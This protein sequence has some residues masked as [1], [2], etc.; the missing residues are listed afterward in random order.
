MTGGNREVT[1]NPSANLHVQYWKKK[2]FTNS[3]NYQKLTNI[4][5][6]YGIVIENKYL[7]HELWYSL[8]SARAH[9]G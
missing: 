2:E 5:C 8:N 9:I 6:R 7:Y 3:T 1:N 4:F